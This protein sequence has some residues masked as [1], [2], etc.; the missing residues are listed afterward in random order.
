[1]IKPVS[2]EKSPV[3]TERASAHPGWWTVLA[4]IAAA[5]LGVP[6]V[7]PV[8]VAIPWLLFRRRDRTSRL[9]PT[10]RWAAAA[11]VTAMALLCLAGE[12][13]VRTIPFGSAA[14]TDVRAWLEGTGGAVPSWVAMA[15]W[16]ALFALAAVVSRGVAGCIVL[17]NALLVSA[18]HASV[19]LA[20]SSNVVYASFVALPIWSFSWLLGMILL[21]DPLAEW[22]TAHVWRV[23][24]DDAQTVSRRRWTAGVGLIAA[25]L[26]IRLLAA[27]LF[28]DFAR[29]LT[30][31]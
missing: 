6:W 21:L 15:V 11:W 20:Q 16:A 4:V 14:A 2:P 8:T 24:R 5:W 30:I 28:T 13:A 26:A 27:P 1:M 18:V 12:R 31:R 17:A 25:A 10:L 9:T 22:G 7:L 29:R 19:I 3:A 23:R